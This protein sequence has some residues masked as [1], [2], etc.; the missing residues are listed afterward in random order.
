MNNTKEDFGHKCSLP[1][2]AAAFCTTRPDYL[3]LS[4]QVSNNE[5]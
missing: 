3:Y 5:L 4:G 1:A 2:A